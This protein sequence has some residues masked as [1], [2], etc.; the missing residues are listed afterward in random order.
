[1]LN[2]NDYEECLYEMLKLTNLVDTENINISN[3][4]NS[5][6]AEDVIA[7]ENVPSFDR[8]PYDGY[9]FN[10]EDTDNA[11]KDNPVILKI[12]D[13][14]PAGKISDKVIAKNEC[15]KILTGAKVPK[16]ADAIC[17]FEDVEYNDEYIKVFNKYE[18]GKNIIYQ[19]EDIKKGTKLIEKGSKINPAC[20]G[21]LCSLGKKNINVYRNVKVGVFSIGS[22][23]LEIG[24]EKDDG[25]IYNSNKWVIEGILKNNNYIVNYYGIAKD[26]IEDIKNIYK[27]A[28]TECDCVISTGGVSVGDYD[29]T[30]DA[31]QQ[32]G[33]DI[34]ARGVKLKPGM[35]CCFAFYDKKP[36]MALSGNPMSSLTT[37]YL[38]SMPILKKMSGLKNYENEMIDIK[39]YND[40]PT[41]RHTYNKI[42]YKGKS[43]IENGNLYL[44]VG[45]KQG[46]I[47]LYSLIN[48][49]F[50][51]IVDSDEELKKGNIVRGIRL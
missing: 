32:I 31:I 41:K 51:A 50:F 9:V 4:L 48:S 25:K 3:S 13:E 23:L 45:N 44:E 36:I 11:T 7:E 1:M 27:K 17:M 10:S 5:I 39:L 16:G 35:A 33:S 22:E 29:L 34:I 43:K 12:I 18:K 46:N 28:L 2:N 47:M 6:I 14:I 42:I 40:L 15:M 20:I 49:D 24:S 37:F 8:S 19:G 38:I 21:C 30:P 26:N